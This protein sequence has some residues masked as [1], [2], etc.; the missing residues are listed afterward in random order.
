MNHEKVIALRNAASR[1][2]ELYQTNAIATH[3]A[4][5]EKI[6]EAAFAVLALRLAETRGDEWRD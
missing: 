2:L 4:A 5:D 6:I 1:V 3:Y